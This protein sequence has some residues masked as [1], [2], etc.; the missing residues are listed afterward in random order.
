MTL[1]GMAID[2]W[3]WRHW[4][5]PKLKDEVIADD[6]AADL[7]EMEAEAMAKEAEQAA[8]VS[9]TKPDEWEEI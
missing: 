5:D 4:E 3:A 6:F 8:A 1:E 9:A 7:A 2:Y